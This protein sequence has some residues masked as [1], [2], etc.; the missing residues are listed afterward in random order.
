MKMLRSAQ[1]S[2]EPAARFTIRS[3]LGLIL[4]CAACN[5]GRDAGGKT[6]GANAKTAAEPSCAPQPGVTPGFLA[7]ADY[8]KTTQPAPMRF[9]TAAGT[10][11]AVSDDGMRALQD[12]GPTYFYAGKESQK[13]KVREKLE[14]AGPFTALLVVMRGDTKN[15]DGTQTIRLGGHFVTGKYDGTNTPSRAYTYA[16]S[17]DGWKMSAVKDEAGS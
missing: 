14:Q 6:A 11:S 7:V 8:I 17:A 13:Q 5:G 1:T 3:G 12:K 15:A 2:R 4:A 16:C 10:D 9:L